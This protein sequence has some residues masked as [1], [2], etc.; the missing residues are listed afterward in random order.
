MS[1][2]SDDWFRDPA[3]RPPGRAGSGYPGASEP[4]ESVFGGGNRAS[5]WGSGGQQPGGAGYRGAWPEQPPLQGGSGGAPV[6]P[7]EGGR[8]RGSGRGYSGGGSSG[9]GRRWLRPRRIMAIIA[10]V[11]VVLLVFSGVMY[12]YLNSKL[13]RANVLVDYAGRPVASAGRPA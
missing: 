11:V 7:Y 1:D 13:T 2:R 8:P 9:Q 4:T 6:P 10:L 12:F 3:P 5:A